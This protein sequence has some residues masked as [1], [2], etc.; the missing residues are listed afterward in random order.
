[1]Q[2]VT[3]VIYRLIGIALVLL[4]CRTSHEAGSILCSTQ[5]KDDIKSNWNFDTV[6]NSYSTNFKFI[7]S[8]DS[9]YKECILGKNKSDII[10][11]FG[12]PTSTSG[13]KGVVGAVATI[14]YIYERCDPTQKD[15]MCFYY[16]FSF[17]AT[18]KVVR[19]YSLGKGG[20]RSH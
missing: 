7:S 6:S 20:F 5:F 4:S 8:L 2:R 3:R 16:V 1:M 14:E 15:F 10:K 11:L 18:Q 17:D 19:A 12:E 13:L 9:T